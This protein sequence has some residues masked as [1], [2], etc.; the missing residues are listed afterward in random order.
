M[1]VK[2]IFKKITKKWKIT[3]MKRPT[4]VAEKAIM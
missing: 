4:M 2:Q 1:F 3:Q